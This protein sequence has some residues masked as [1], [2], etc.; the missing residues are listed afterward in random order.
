[1]YPTF[2]WC[3]YFG[4]LFLSYCVIKNDKNVAVSKEKIVAASSHQV[5]EK[6]K[7]QTEYQ[8]HYINYTWPSIQSYA[9]AF[10]RKD[11]VPEN[12]AMVGIKFYKDKLYI[13]LPR[14]RKG[15]PVTLA[16]MSTNSSD[17]TNQLLAPFPSWEMNA[18]KDCSTL[19]N[20]YSMEIDRR[21]V[22]WVLDG[23]RVNNFTK[24]PP[25]LVLLDLNKKGKLVQSYEFSSEL[26]STEGGF[27]NDIV[28]DESDGGYAY[29]TENS[30]KDPGIIVYSR[31]RNRAWKIRDSSMFA[32]LEAANFEVDGLKNTGLIPVDGIALA[33]QPTLRNEDRYVFYSALTGFSLYALST[34]IFKNEEVCQGDS[35]RRAIKYVGRKQSQ[36][37]GF[38]MDNKGNLY[39]G[40]LASY[41]VAKWNIHTPFST[42][43]VLD[44]N[45]RE[46]I[47][48]DSFGFDSKGNLY[49]L[50]NGIN[51]FY[52]PS[53]K[54]QVTTEIK[55]RILKHTT[56]TISYLY[57]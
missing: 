24:C 25:K 7:F 45:K 18:Q 10:K 9:I 56:Q 12:N 36:A 14:I 44:Q 31:L 42:S 15:T 6:H 40:L 21:G 33:P 46:L 38:A 48:P 32:E 16:Q 37:D 5:E 55:F 28:I 1:M 8:W 50:A 30:A 34:K 57:N 43:K 3:D 39:Y 23:F 53:Y 26:C 52:D 47:W 27:L 51:K 4:F 17:K 29:I 41:G 22:M 19:Q 2:R 11:Y 20:V 54:L 35:W 49:V 13:A